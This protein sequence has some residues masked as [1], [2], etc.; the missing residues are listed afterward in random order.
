MFNERYLIHSTRLVIAIMRWLIVYWMTWIQNICNPFLLSQGKVQTEALVMDCTLLL[1]DM[2]TS[3][4]SSYPWVSDLCS[5][6]VV[7]G[8]YIKL[9]YSFNVRIML[10]CTSAWL[11]EFALWRTQ[12][13][14]PGF[15]R[16]GA[17]LLLRS[18]IRFGYLKVLLIS[19]INCL[20]AIVRGLWVW[21]CI[22]H[23]LV[24]F[25]FRRNVLKN[26]SFHHACI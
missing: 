24:V 1:D 18:F 10:D 5:E 23:Y 22:Y 21:R 2:C 7:D 19:T 8:V 26:F 15:G 17:D 6:A 20:R 4:P 16:E 13:L 11:Y 14:L 3:Y 12:M 25:H 9:G